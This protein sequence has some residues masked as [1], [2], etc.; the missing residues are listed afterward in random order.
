MDIRDIDRD[1]LVMELILTAK[2]GRMDQYEIVQAE[3]ERRDRDCF[4]GTQGD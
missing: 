4:E 2:S 3:L 1:T